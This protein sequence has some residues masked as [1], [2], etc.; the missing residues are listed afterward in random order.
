MNDNDFQKFI[1]KHPDVS[2]LGAKNTRQIVDLYRDRIQ[3]LQD[4]QDKLFDTLIYYLKSNKSIDFCGDDE[5]CIFDYV[6]NKFPSTQLNHIL[7]EKKI[8]KI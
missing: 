8:D 7:I 5:E 4:E 2:I 3:I 6:Y 1:S